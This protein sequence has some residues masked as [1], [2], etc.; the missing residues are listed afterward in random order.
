M[1]R[2][3]NQTSGEALF[4][5]T[6]ILQML[7]ANCIKCVNYYFLFFF[8]AISLVPPQIITKSFFVPILKPH[9]D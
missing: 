9:I 5:V 4:T 2:A 6:L 3:A 8:L 1:R 7:F